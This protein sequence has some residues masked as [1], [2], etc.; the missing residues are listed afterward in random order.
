MS[1]SNA[2]SQSS[3][4]GTRKGLLIKIGM[5]IAILVVGM[6]GMLGIKAT[7]QDSEEKKPVDTRPNISYQEIQPTNHTV[8]ITGNGEIKQKNLTQHSRAGVW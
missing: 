8:M 7:A 2:S 3:A 6:A 4:N 1:I 5:P